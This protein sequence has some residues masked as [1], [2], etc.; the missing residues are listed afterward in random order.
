SDYVYVTN[1]YFATSKMRNGDTRNRFIG[2]FSTRYNFTDY[3][4]A[5]ARVGLD[6]RNTNDYDI[7]Q[8]SGTA[9][10]NRGRMSEGQSYATSLNSE[11][12]FGFDK[13]F[14]RFSITALA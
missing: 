5:R 8:P 14:N 3:L 1:P 12:L 7:S 13:S 2:S 6:Q 9:Y 4:Y 11:L 10:D